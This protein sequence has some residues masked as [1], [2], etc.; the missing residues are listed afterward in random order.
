MNCYILS[1]ANLELIELNIEDYIK[2]I[3]KGETNPDLVEGDSLVIFDPIS[4]NI[5]SLDDISGLWFNIFNGQLDDVVLTSEENA[6]E[7]LDNLYDYGRNLDL[8]DYSHSINNNKR[9]VLTEYESTVYA[10]NIINFRRN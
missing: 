1:R 3:L 9:Y 10:D 5:R 8:F 7:Y 2:I 6:I 4:G